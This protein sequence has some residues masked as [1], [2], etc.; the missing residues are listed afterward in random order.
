[1]RYEQWPWIL[2]RPDF[3]KRRLAAVK[4]A[5]D[6]YEAWK[7]RPGWREVGE[8]VAGHN[9]YFPGEDDDEEDPPEDNRDELA[10]KAHGLHVLR[11]I[12]AL[13]HC[14]ILDVGFHVVLDDDE[15]VRWM[16][17]SAAPLYHLV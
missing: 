11:F 4:A 17:N 6:D 5:Q 3:P 16:P 14:A 13:P 1:V 15:W 2:V 12:E 7:L 8:F 10:V 9:L